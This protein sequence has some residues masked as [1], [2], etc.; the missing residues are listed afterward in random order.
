MHFVLLSCICIVIDTRSAITA[1]PVSCV[2]T[3]QTRHHLVSVCVCSLPSCCAERYG[4]FNP[5][6]SIT[7]AAATAACLRKI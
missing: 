4:V 6:S 7:A 5:Q 3:Y 2:L 1:A